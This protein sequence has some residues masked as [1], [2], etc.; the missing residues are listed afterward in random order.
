M[1]KTFY[2]LGFIFVLGFLYTACSSTEKKVNTIAVDKKEMEAPFIKLEEI[3]IGTQVWTVKNYDG[4]TFLN[5]DPIPE[6]KTKEAWIQANQKKQPAWCYYENKPENG[7]KYGKLYNWYAIN[8]PR[9]FAPKGW[10]VPTAQDWE[11]LIAFLGGNVVAG[12]KLKSTSQ[13]ENTFD[14]KNGN[15]SNES[16]FNA[17]PTGYIKSNGSFMGAGRESFWWTSTEKNNETVVARNLVSNNNRAF[18]TDLGKDN[19]LALRL[20]KE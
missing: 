14:G 11:N 7:E 5:G 1:K 12:G 16:G 2:T 13:W 4:T 8:D 3:K 9:G 10:K 6:A 17:F 18:K 19:G 20:I 15:G